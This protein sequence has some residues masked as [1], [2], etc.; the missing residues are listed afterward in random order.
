MCK[1]VIINRGE[2]ELSTP[3]EFKEYFGFLP[4]KNQMFSIRDDEGYSENELEECLCSADLTKSLEQ[5]K[6]EFKISW[7]DFYVGELTLVEA[8]IRLK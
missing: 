6:I 7:G 3:K 5:N 1:K 2:Y 8:D 4:T